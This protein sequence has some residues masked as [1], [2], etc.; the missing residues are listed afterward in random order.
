[1]VFG[2]EEV[3]GGWERWSLWQWLGFLRR[4]KNEDER[5]IDL[6]LKREYF[7]PIST[8]PKAE[9]EEALANLRLLRK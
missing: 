4:T 1:V 8:W 2:A 3:G 5:G 9:R 7:L 6:V